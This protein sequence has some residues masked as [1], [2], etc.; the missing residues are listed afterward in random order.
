MAQQ[1]RP[2]DRLFHSVLT[3]IVAPDLAARFTAPEFGHHAT[4]LLIRLT[5]QKVDTFVY[6]LCE[7]KSVPD[8]LVSRQLL[9]YFRALWHR[10][11]NEIPDGR[12]PGI[13]PIALY[14]GRASWKPPEFS[15]LVDGAE[16]DDVPRFAFREPR[17]GSD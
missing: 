17:R 11:R 1:D 7:H 9:R 8:P 3:R 13:I 2:C 6:V 15:G 14:H 12:S 10:L 4:D 5:E 16:G